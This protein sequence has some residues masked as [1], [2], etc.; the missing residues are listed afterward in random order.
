MSTGAGE[1]NRRIEIDYRVAGVGPVGQPV[2]EWKLLFPRWAKILTQTG[3]G[4]IK[5][6]AEG[7]LANV[8][9]RASFRI[10]Y[11]RQVDAGMRVRYQGAIY[12][13]IGVSPDLAGHKYVDL[14]CE[15]G[16]SDG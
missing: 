8:V 11:T 15:T 6:A 2:N 5:M 14:I 12:E 7:G 9:N 10:R 1:Y 13:I 16:A 4:A 3:M